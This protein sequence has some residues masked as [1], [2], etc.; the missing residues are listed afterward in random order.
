MGTV[1]ATPLIPRWASWLRENPGCKV[2]MSADVYADFMKE[3]CAGEFLPSIVRSE[4]LRAGSIYGI[5]GITHRMAV[6]FSRQ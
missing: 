6:D 2:V 5:D 4:I 3:D 1:P